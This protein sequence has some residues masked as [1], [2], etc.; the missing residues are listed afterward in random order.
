MPCIESL[1]IME[2]F[3]L[4]QQPQHY[5]ESRPVKRYTGTPPTH[6][7]GLPGAPPTHPGPIRQ[8]SVPQY[9][10]YNHQQ[11]RRIT[12]PHT[13]QH[14]QQQ[15]WGIG[16]SRQLA[17]QTRVS[18]T[19]P[20]TFRGRIQSAST[21]PQA[22]GGPSYDSLANAVREVKQLNTQQQ[23]NAKLR[24]QT[25]GARERNKFLGQ[26]SRGGRPALALP[27]Q[28]QDGL[29]QAFLVRPA[30]PHLPCSLCHKPVGPQHLIAIPGLHLHYH[31]HCFA[32]PVC[33]TLLVP[34]RGHSSTT[35]MVRS[36]RPHCHYC[37][38]NP[39]GK[40]YHI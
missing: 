26:P 17:E 14:P 4:P 3:L 29:Q 9:L 13:P 38:S 36:M 22:N 8:R 11:R 30:D 34:S 33:H 28:K 35:V 1:K 7:V 40:N 16:K 32:C 25:W 24:S 15:Q 39:Q 19:M 5:E 37:T 20:A 21:P 18:G 23:Q 6:Q 27:E 12:P 2:L 31:P 10:T